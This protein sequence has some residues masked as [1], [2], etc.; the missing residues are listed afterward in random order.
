M[1]IFPVSKLKHHFVFISWFSTG[2]V[3]FEK[4]RLLMTNHLSACGSNRLICRHLPVSLSVLHSISGRQSASSVCRVWR[5]TDSQWWPWWKVA[6]RRSGSGAPGENSSTDCSLDEEWT[7]PAAPSA[8]DRQIAATLLTHYKVLLLHKLNIW[9]ATQ[10]CRVVLVKYS[11]IQ[12]FV[13][14][15]KLLALVLLTYF[16]WFSVMSKI[17]VKNW[18][19]FLLG[20]DW[21]PSWPL[22]WASFW[23]SDTLG[24]KPALGRPIK[25]IHGPEVGKSSKNCVCL[26]RC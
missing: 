14:N 10:S 21:S 16:L 11:F 1:F 23:L 22:N 13:Q 18:F 25:K 17:S 19:I 6:V 24:D 4:L 15:P 2:E 3:C 5:A 9:A 7:R 8:K 26:S 20:V 12:V